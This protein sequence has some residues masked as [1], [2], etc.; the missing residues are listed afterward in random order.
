MPVYPL[1]KSQATCP[2]SAGTPEPPTPAE[3]RPI[4]AGQARL[5][6]ERSERGLP[7]DVRSLFNLAFAYLAITEAERD[8]GEA[9]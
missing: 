9:A 8:D 1:R 3:L 4:F 5:L 7:V 6:A 2:L